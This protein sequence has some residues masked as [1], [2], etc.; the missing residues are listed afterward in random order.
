MSPFLAMPFY[1]YMRTYKRYAFEFWEN[2]SPAQ[3]GMVLV[4][5]FVLGYLMMKSAR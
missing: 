3:Y 5:V 1:S 2:L 4:V